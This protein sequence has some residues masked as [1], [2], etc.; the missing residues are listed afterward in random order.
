[1]TIHVTP[2]PSTIELAAPA[3]TLGVANAAGAA[4]T[5]VSSNST[6]L[7]FDTTAVDAI[8][9]GQSGSV[10]SAT[11]ASRRDHAHEMESATVTAAATQAEMEAASSTTIMVTPGRT[12]FHPAVCK[13]YG[14]TTNFGSVHTGSY[15]VTSFAKVTTGIGTWTWAVSF[16]DLNYSV[17]MGGVNDPGF[18]EEDDTSGKTE[19]TMVVH[20]WT[21]DGSVALTDIVHAVAAFGLQE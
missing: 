4:L 15:G 20:C 1:L 17:A 16:D 8:T 6:L 19:D 3:F 10:G 7:T 11:T 21:A 14:F 12:Q 5:A 13:A 9:F 2:V 18:V